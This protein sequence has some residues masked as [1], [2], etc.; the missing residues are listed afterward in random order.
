MEIISWICTRY[1]TLQDAHNI[2]YSSQ[3]SSPVIT[4]LSFKQLNEIWENEA[5]RG[6]CP[7]ICSS[8]LCWLSLQSWCLPCMEPETVLARAAYIYVY[9]NTTKPTKLSYLLSLHYIALHLKLLLKTWALCLWVLCLQICDDCPQFMGHHSSVSTA[10]VVIE[11][12]MD[13]GILVL[14]KD[15]AA[16][17][18]KSRTVLYSLRY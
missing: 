1:I 8:S 16:T 9:T 7:C 4:F 10:Q 18:D 2:Q 14:W 12:I 5:H 17:D 11:G 13:E 3:L 15:H 6:T